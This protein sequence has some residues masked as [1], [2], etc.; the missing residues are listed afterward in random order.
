[1][2]DNY[3]EFST[4]VWVKATSIEKL[5][6]LE[7]ALDDPQVPTLEFDLENPPNIK[8]WM[9]PHIKELV[10]YILDYGNFNARVEIPEP[11]GKP[12]QQLF[13]YSEDNGDV[14]SAALYL[15]VLLRCEL[16]VEPDQP[17]IL[18]WANTCNKPR[19]DEFSGG[20]CVITKSKIYWHN[21]EEWVNSIKQQIA[22]GV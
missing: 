2:A 6:E 20:I 1:M 19:P 12:Y 14:E 10:A 7:I 17:I 5:K 3:T 15:Q 21:A 4:A 16:V 13:I 9:L 22:A 11:G 18:T 8:G